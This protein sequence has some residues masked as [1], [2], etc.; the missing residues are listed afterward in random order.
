MLHTEEG[1]L[2][3]YT[4][5]RYEVPGVVHSR[6]VKGPR[7]SARRCVRSL[8]LYIEVRDERSLDMYTEKMG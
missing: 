1:S 5:D 2:E 3:L 4:K 7:S 8:E 6:G